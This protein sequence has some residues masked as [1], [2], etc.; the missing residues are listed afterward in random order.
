MSIAQPFRGSHFERPAA[1]LLGKIGTCARGRTLNRAFGGHYRHRPVT[2]LK[3]GA[4][5]GQ[6]EPIY[7]TWQA[8]ALPLSYTREKLERD[9]GDNPVSAGWKPADLINVV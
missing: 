6:D 9:T 2:G 8:C 7:Q 4:G 5:N 3:N 1:A